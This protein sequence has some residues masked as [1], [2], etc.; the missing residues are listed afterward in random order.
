MNDDNFATPPD[1]AAADVERRPAPGTKKR[2]GGSRWVNVLVGVAVL[3][4]VGGVTFAIGRAT[5]PVQAAQGPGAG[6][7]PG[8]FPGGSFNPGQFLG[9][10]LGNRTVSGTVTSTNGSTM[11]LTTSNGQTQTVDVSG[12]TYH[13][14]VAAG[15][16]D[17]TQGTQVEITLDGGQ[18]FPGGPLASPGTVA[19][20]GQTLKAG[21]V[22][23]VGH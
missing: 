15:A 4:F 6:Q 10:G 3:V 7:F 13:T 14:K 23:I 5:A 8:N 2:S 18:G 19:S 21:D 16:T 20:A 22:T 12:T 1:S 11:T 17:V 9:G